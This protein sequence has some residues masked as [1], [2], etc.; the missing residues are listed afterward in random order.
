MSAVA[1]N[2]FIVASGQGAHVTGADGRT[3]LDAT[4]AL[5]YCNV[6]HGRTEMADAAAAQMRSIAS[7]SNFGDYATQSTLDL[8]DRLAALSGL[9]DAKVFF[10]SGGSDAVDTALKMVSR[11]WSLVGEPQRTRI[12]ARERS[13]HGMHVAGTSLGGIPANREGHGEPDPKVKNVTWDDA[14]AL[15]AEIDAIGAEN[16][17]AFFCEPVIGAGGVYPPPDGYLARVRDICKERG[18]LL[19]ADE[20]ISGYGRTGSM[21]ASQRWDLQPDLML[22]AKGLTSGYLPMGAVLVSGRVAEPFWNTPGLIWRHGYTYSGH[23]TAAAVASVNLDIIERE[24]L[25]DRVADLAPVLA[26]ALNPLA[27]HSH[28][29]A[30]RT[31]GLLGAVQLRPD[32]IKED[33]TIGAR[34]VRASREQGVLTRWLADGGLQVSPPF[35]ITREDLHAMGRAF[36]VALASVGSTRAKS[37]RLHVDLLPDTTTDEAGGFESSDARLRADVPPHHGT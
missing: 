19:V 13:Y 5:W 22:T 34:L 25:V 3:Y 32:V 6:G 16:V 37:D 28:V 29:A 14:E 8:A 31:V 35:V 1:G 26:A 24:Q 2:D 11:Y 7:Y 23:A 15:A 36:D 30:V 17:A 20:V 18:V 12:I 27:A 10:T 21:F 4:A 33:P 9:T